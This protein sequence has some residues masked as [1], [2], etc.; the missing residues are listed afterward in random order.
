MF[1]WVV[2]H[3]NFCHSG[4]PHEAIR[5]HKQSH[6]HLV[7]HELK[8]GL[9]QLMNPRVFCK[10]TDDECRN[11]DNNV[12][13]HEPHEDPKQ[14]A[15]IAEDAVRGHVD[16]VQVP[17]EPVAVLSEGLAEV[18]E[19]AP[20][21]NEPEV[22]DH[23]VHLAIEVNNYLRDVA[24][25]QR[26]EHEHLELSKHNIHSIAGIFEEFCENKVE[27]D[28]DTQKSNI[29]FYIIYFKIYK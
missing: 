5:K 23:S 25:N 26:S 11:S 8:Q 14:F 17:V 19:H 27:K 12:D 10:E 9:W 29:H 6:E 13:S 18:D 24:A 1:L 28:S 21:E 22:E 3:S 20:V 4:K 7:L 2:N 16:E 15:H